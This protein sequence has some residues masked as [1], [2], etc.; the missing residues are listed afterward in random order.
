MPKSEYAAAN[1][2]RAYPF[3]D[4]D[5]S[6]FFPVFSD[7]QVI[8]RP[9]AQY[10]HGRHRVYLH[11]LGSLTG[12]QSSVIFGD[13]GNNR[14]AALSCDAPGLQNTLLVFP[15]H[16]DDRRYTRSSGTLVARPAFLSLLFGELL[17]PVEDETG[18]KR[19]EG[20]MLFGKSELLP[21]SP[22]KLTVPISLEPARIVNSAERSTR[23][24][25]TFVYNQVL[26]QYRPP[27]GCETFATATEVQ[28]GQY[29]LACGPIEGPFRLAGGHGVRVAQDTGRRQLFVTADRTPGELGFACDPIPVDGELDDTDTSP[30]CNEVLRS[31]NGAEGPVLQISP[32]AGVDIGSFPD[33]SRVVIAT[34]ANDIGLCPERTPAE[35][36]QYLPTDELDRP[37]GN[38]GEPLPPPPG[39]P[40]KQ[41]G[42]LPNPA[43]TPLAPTTAAPT[44]CQ[45]LKTENGFEL[46][47]YPCGSPTSCSEPDP[48]AGTIGDIISTACVLYSDEFGLL[49]QNPFFL[50]DIPLAAWDTEGEVTVIFED[51]DLPSEA[52][53]LARL[54]G[55]TP[56]TTLTQ[57]QIQVTANR[58]YLLQFGYR[59]RQGTGE[60]AIGPE[61]AFH[62]AKRVSLVDDDGL[63]AWQAV[64]ILVDLPTNLARL[65][66]TAGPDAIIEI[67]Q[68][69]LVEQ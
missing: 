16:S 2:A 25:V 63:A 40:D 50:A 32:L 45:W 35:P 23:L 6:A 69:S 12:S 58:T 26:T 64:E 60:L 1:L 43:S 56:N 39:L 28:T 13:A 59:I 51:P 21:A 65:V 68:F 62:T 19:W 33:Q 47:V 29:R 46:Q 31:I 11:S 67:G 41:A 52:L 42:Y 30:R 48:G 61:V 66:I 9:E 3:V 34:S 15:A 20:H 22:L 8:I 4:N 5:Q 24:G 27:A 54:T 37:C 36:V 14:F 10:R 17:T 38:D 49:I 55:D 18:L 53:P 44:L 57:R 7:A